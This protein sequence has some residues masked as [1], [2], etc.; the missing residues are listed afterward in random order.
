MST[1]SAATPDQTRQRVQVLLAAAPGMRE[2]LQER[3]ESVAESVGANFDASVRICALSQIDKDPFP[4]MNPHSSGFDAVIDI[5]GA[6]ELLARDTVLNAL[7]NVPPTLSGVIDDSASGVTVGWP[8]AV[9]P[10]PRCALRYLYLMRRKADVSR[11]DYFDHYF[12]R[13]SEFAFH[14]NGIKAYTQ[15]HVDIEASNEL[16][17]ALGFGLRDVDSVTELTFDSVNE[18]F[19]GVEPR[20]AEASEDEL[21][22]VDREHSVS[23][24]S[25]DTTIRD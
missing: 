11:E 14:L 9:I 6:S 10:G 21:L 12:H 19:A 18:F 25:I 4:S 15:V 5:H 3:I 1:M 23:F 2:M 24:C 20:A 13:H 7:Q 22:F 16:S 17:A 8:Q